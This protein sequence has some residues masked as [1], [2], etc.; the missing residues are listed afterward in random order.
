MKRWSMRL[1]DAFKYVI[2]DYTSFVNFGSSHA[3]EYI[4][5][6][7][8]SAS[9]PFGSVSFIMRNVYMWSTAAFMISRISDCVMCE[10]PQQSHPSF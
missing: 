6:I 5:P 3:A 7:L 10:Y 9:Y 2:T 8:S 4:S 1:S